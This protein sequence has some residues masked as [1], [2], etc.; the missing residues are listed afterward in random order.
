M[1]TI[2]YRA[3]D[4]PDNNVVTFIEHNLEKDPEHIIFHWVPRE[5]LSRWSFRLDDLLDH[6][7]ITLDQFARGVRRMAAGFRELSIQKGDRV[8]VFLP[9]SVGMYTVMFAL[10]RIGAIPVFLDSW[11]RRRNLG[12]TAQMT[13]P[14]AMV[15]LDQAFLAYEAEPGLV[16]IP[17]KVSAGPTDKVYTASIEELIET[18]AEAAV[19]PVAQEDT[20]LITFTTGSSGQPKGANRTHRFLA[21]QHYALNEIIPYLPSD[22]DLPVFPIF[23]LNNIAAGATTVIPAIDLGAP[24]EHDPLTLLAQMKACNVTCATFSPSLLNSVSRYCLRNRISIKY[25]RRSHHRWGADKPR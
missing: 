21:G 19:T 13:T 14:K 22:V 20:A 15:S 11:A 1:S 17:I 24:S 9:M 18:E 4:T 6:E 8:I 12:V 10:Q 25:L 3:G 2:G 7:S 23:C 5:K 16:S